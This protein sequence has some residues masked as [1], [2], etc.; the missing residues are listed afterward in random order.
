MFDFIK[1]D[2]F[3][4]KD[5][6]EMKFGRHFRLKDGAKLV[7]GRNQEENAYLQ[8]IDNDKYMHMKTIGLPGP[9]AL[10]SKNASQEDKDIATKAIFTYCKTD[11]NSLYKVSF[12]GQEVTGSPFSSREEMKP[13]TI[14]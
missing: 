5:I 8:D 13:F 7:I 1:Y 6:P 9:H 3:T 2:T 11:L 12:D 4:V 14:L 10:L